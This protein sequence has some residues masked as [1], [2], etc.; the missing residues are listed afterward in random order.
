M[1]HTIGLIGKPVTFSLRRLL[2]RRNPCSTLSSLDLATASIS[3]ACQPAI[4]DPLSKAFPPMIKYGYSASN[5]TLTTS[6]RLY[7]VKLHTLMTR[8]S[9]IDSGNI[10]INHVDYI[11]HFLSLTWRVLRIVIITLFFCLVPLPCFLLLSLN[12][13]GINVSSLC[14]LSFARSFQVPLQVNNALV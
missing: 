13:Q 3:S 11:F 4:G 9:A 7:G 10:I 8:K 1:I 6:N 14:R 5:T 2:L 12:L